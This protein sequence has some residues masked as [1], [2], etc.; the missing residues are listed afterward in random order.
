M[1]S[2]CFSVHV[3]QAHV[4]NPIGHTEVVNLHE[5]PMEQVRSQCRLSNE[6]SLVLRVPDQLRKQRLDR[7]L[8]R[9][10]TCT[11]DFGEKHLARAATAESAKQPIRP[12]LTGSRVEVGA[13][14]A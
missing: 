11:V 2:E 12:E 5:I 10:S 14:H 7:H 13:R 6:Q 9:E 1:I 3:I 4:L 8:L